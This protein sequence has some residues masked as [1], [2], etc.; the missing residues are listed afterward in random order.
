MYLA[1]TEGK[2]ASRH[3][4]NH[5]DQRKYEGRHLYSEGL[6]LGCPKDSVPLPCWA[7]G[8][9]EVPGRFLGFHLPPQ[10]D[11]MPVKTISV[12][13]SLEK[14]VPSKWKCEIFSPEIC[15]LHEGRAAVSSVS[16]KSH[17]SSGVRMNVLSQLWQKSEALMLLVFAGANWEPRKGRNCKKSWL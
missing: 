7:V 8:A 5:N 1:C 3:T 4:T 9:A 6:C 11:H 10:L 14:N 17:S 12:I 13:W 2:A 15:C 16:V